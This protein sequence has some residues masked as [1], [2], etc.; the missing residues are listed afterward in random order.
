M[1]HP[2]GLPAVPCPAT[3]W[4]SGWRPPASPAGAVFR[5]VTRHGAVGERALSG[6]SVARIVKRA[7][8]LAGLEPGAFAGHSLRAGLA[9]SAARAR[10]TER[11]IMRQT[12]HTSAAMVRRYIREAGVFEDNAAEGLL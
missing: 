3:A 4:P 5:E 1:G 11:D 7:A 10:K 12:R 9:S 8:V 2:Q 6:A